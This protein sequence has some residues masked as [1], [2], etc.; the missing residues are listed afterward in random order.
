MESFPSDID[1][2]SNSLDFMKE[3][4]VAERKFKIQ[5]KDITTLCMGLYIL[6]QSIYFG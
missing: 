5:D 3:V 6:M 4:D 1:N 2:I